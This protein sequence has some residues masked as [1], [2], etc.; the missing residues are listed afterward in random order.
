MKIRELRLDDLPI[1]VQWMNN[2]K[3]NSSMHFTLPILIENTIEWFQRNSSN[4]YR[5]DVVFLE[6][7]EIVAFGGL[8]SITE[9]TKKAELYVFVSPDSQCS[10]LGSKATEL[11]CDWGFSKLGLSKIYLYT[12]EDNV[13]AI[14]VYEKCGFLLE[15]RLRNEYLCKNGELKDRLYYGKLKSDHVYPEP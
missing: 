13:A 4:P 7:D 5:S 12:N 11:L 10:G 3:V 1:R 6:N 15:G 14:R 9:D 2:P 8:T